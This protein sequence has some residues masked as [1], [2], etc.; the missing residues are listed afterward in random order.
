MQG[1]HRAYPQTQNWVQ[2][3]PTGAALETALRFKG[4]DSRTS[5]VQLVVHSTPSSWL[6]TSSDGKVSLTVLAL[7]HDDCLLLPT[8]RHSCSVPI[9]AGTWHSH[10]ERGWRHFRRDGPASREGAGGGGGWFDD[11]DTASLE[12]RDAMKVLKETVLSIRIYGLRV[13]SNTSLQPRLLRAPKFVLYNHTINSAVIMFT[14]K[15]ALFFSIAAA[16]FATV[17]VPTAATFPFPGPKDGL[18]CAAAARD[19][20]CSAKTGSVDPNGF[21]TCCYNGALKPDFKESGLV[22]A[23]QFYDT[24]PSIGPKDSTTIHGLWPDYCDG[25]YPAVSILLR[26]PLKVCPH[27]LLTQ[28]RSP[29]LLLAAI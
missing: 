17:I 24:A 26:F 20:S 10:L 7:Q 15:S 12:A 21:G 28:M 2:K 9:N 13:I 22:L 5:R 11:Y 14:S 25:S 8:D 4:L 6:S 19:V 3:R 1:L 16:T 23:T 27:F 29:L 18:Q